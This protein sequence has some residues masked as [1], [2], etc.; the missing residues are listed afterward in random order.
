[1]ATETYWCPGPWPWEWF[2]TCSREVPD[3]PCNAPPC[4]NA[5]AQLLDARRRINSIC[6]ALRTLLA[7]LKLLRGIV[8]TPIWVIAVMALIAA[9]IGGP[10][11]VIIWSLI[12]VYGIS[13]VLVLV[14]ARMV[15]SLGK[16]LENA[17]VDFQKA[18]VEVGL[19]CPE[20]CRGDISIPECPLD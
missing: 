17:R 2:R 9:L 13:F 4:T 7:L 8:S 15:D 11:A 14:L 16:S 10:I 12:A 6:F 20:H 19:H 5:K 1:M 18:L 3:D